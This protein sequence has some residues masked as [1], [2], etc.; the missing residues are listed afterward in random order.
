MD[1]PDLSFR[2][3]VSAALSTL[4]NARDILINRVHRHED[5]LGCEATEPRKLRLFDRGFRP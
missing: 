1:R 5:H 2:R 3:A 4:D